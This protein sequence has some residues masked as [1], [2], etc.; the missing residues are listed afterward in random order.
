M[1]KIPIDPLDGPQY[2]LRGRIVTMN[3]RRSIISDGIVYIDKGKI[4]ALSKSTAT[5]PEGFS[6]IPVVNTKGTIY[7]G[8]I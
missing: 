7:P 5:A 2:A 8:L 6:G 1:A 4:V 3:S